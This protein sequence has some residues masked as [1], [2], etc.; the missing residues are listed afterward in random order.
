MGS[1]SLRYHA[2]R[3]QRYYWFER[4][5]VVG[6]AFLS[7][8]LIFLVLFLLY[9]IARGF[10]ISFH[11]WGVFGRP[12]FIGLDN[13]SS[14]IRDKDFWSS[15]WHTLYFVLLSTMPLV[16]IGLLVALGLN[17]P[18]RWKALARGMFFFPYLLTVS[19]VGTIWRWLLQDQYGIV[20][21]YMENLG[22]PRLHWLGDA[23]WAMPSIAISTIWWTV[24]F[25]IVVFLAALQD[26]PEHLYEAARIDGATPRQ[27]F[28]Y[29]TLPLLSPTTL[30]VV[31]M[32]VIASF[33]IFGQ[34]YV[35]TGGGPYGSTRVLVQYIYEQGFR[36]FKMGYASALAY[37]LFAVMFV[38]T[39][40]Q[41][42]LFSREQG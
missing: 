27:S 34:V 13:Y 23:R 1:T 26:I 28:W 18:F 15:M 5:N 36:Y 35:M 11:E 38:F 12:D 39:M 24:G 41:W 4:D 40:L 20:N 29:I 37:I 17:M 19:V 31:I 10:Y 32:Q 21:Y 42:R 2:P 9:P 3:H 16:V 6:Y 8:Y 25:N 14:L 30:F 33:Q 22:L 7:P